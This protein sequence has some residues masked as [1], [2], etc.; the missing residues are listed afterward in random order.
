MP[1]LQV[2]LFGKLNITWD[3]QPVV[4]MD[5]RK[6]QELFCYLVLH[7]DHPHA[8]EVLA[9]LLWG[10]NPTSHAK[11][12]LRQ[13]LWQLQSAFN[14]AITSADERLV[15][16]EAEWVQLNTH[17][18]CW[19]D[20]AEIEY[21]FAATQGRPGEQLDAPAATLVRDAIGLY[22]GDL[23]EGW[24]Q[25]WCL[26]E[27]ERLQNIYLALLDKLMAYCA[28]T[29][30]YE[31]GLAYGALVLRYDRARER[32]YRS[33]MHLH[34]LLGDRAAALR[35]YQRCTAA[36][37]E[38]L[39][40][41]PSRRTMDLYMQIHSDQLDLPASAGVPDL[42]PPRQAVSLSG[43]LSHVKQVLQS[44]NHFE[45]ELHDQVLML[46]QTL[47]KYDESTPPD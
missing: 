19:L 31:A 17:A 21:A 45:Q 37:N 22:R 25:D 16:V 9:G 13:T 6:V 23:L 18:S 38:E 32:T 30:D 2:R 10:D 24:Y 28:V 40:V 34:H 5:V 26:Y 1:C 12:S 14:A 3:D 39:G 11:K 15:L 44:L 35:Q 42:L 8:R 4:G 27:R 20:I 7:R 47:R 36:L 29:A 46:E 41:K 33:L 43:L